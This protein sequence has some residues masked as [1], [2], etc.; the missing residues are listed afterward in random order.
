[1][2]VLIVLHGRDMS[3]EAM[4]NTTDFLPV[5]GRAVVVYP[6][7]YDLSWN[8]GSC[9]GGAQRAGVDDVAFLA[10]LVHHVVATVPGASASQVYLVGFSNGGRMAYRMACADPGLFAGVAAVEAVP[11][12]SCAA[13]RPIPLAIVAYQD[14][15]LLT[16]APPEPPR[17]VEGYIEPRVDQVVATWRH[18]DGCPAAPIVREEGT[19]SVS[20]WSGCSDHTRFQYDLYAGG[21]HHWPRGNAATPSA[22]QLI[23]RFFNQTG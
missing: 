20:S 21:S 11:V 6:Q 4:A 2:P 15:P 9:C 23:W 5:V 8:A 13:P 22:T 18:A 14:D 12:M 10:D 1:M 7:G 3:P 17:R 16:I 19:V